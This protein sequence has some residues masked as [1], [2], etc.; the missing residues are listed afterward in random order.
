MCKTICVLAAALTLSMSSLMAEQLADRSDKSERHAAE[1]EKAA[2]EK[3]LAAA[4]GGDLQAQKEMASLYMMISTGS[5]ASLRK[6]GFARST[7]DAMNK[8]VF[9]LRKAAEQGDR[10]SQFQ[11]GALYLGHWQLAADDEIAIR[12]D[13]SE[14]LKWFTAAAEQ[15]EIAAQSNLGDFFL[16]GDGVERNVVQAYKW[17]YLASRESPHLRERLSRTAEQMS[18]E[19]IAEAERLAQAWLRAHS[20]TRAQ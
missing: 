18:V 7:A 5:E 19:E 8:G 6:S 9:W 11:L 20:S 16:N 12:P 14:A 2:L 17:Y 1:A 4:K 10:D 15:G 3:I 13:M